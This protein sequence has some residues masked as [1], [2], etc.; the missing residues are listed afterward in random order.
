MTGVQ[1]C[2]LPIYKGLKAQEN[3]AT[4]QVISSEDETIKADFDK[5]KDEYLY[6]GIDHKIDAKWKRTM[7]LRINDVWFVIW[8]IISCFTIVPVSTFLSR[9]K[10]LKGIVKGVAI[11]LGICLILAILGGVTYAILRRCGVFG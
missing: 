9:I 5:N 7:L 8:A 3:K 4:A 6:H 10:A 11:V 1:T 2:A